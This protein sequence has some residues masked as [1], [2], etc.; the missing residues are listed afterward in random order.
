MMVEGGRRK[1][2]IPGRENVR[3]MV[4]EI[5]EKEQNVGK[6]EKKVT[7]NGGR[8]KEQKLPPGQKGE[9]GTYLGLI[10]L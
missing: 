1:L 7:S 9:G 6:R 4:E 5:E 2:E 10:K 3:K 8:K